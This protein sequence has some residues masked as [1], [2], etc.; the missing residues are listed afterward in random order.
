MVDP[1]ERREHLF[2]LVFRDAGAVVGNRYGDLPSFSIFGIGSQINPDIGAVTHGIV[3][4]VR[5]NPVQPN[6][7]P[8]V[9]YADTKA[10]NA[11]GIRGTPGFTVN[12]YFVSGAQPF[13]AFKKAIEKAK[14]DQKK[15]K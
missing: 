3:D 12:G 2:L 1:V 5:K 15:K 4:Q 9:T 14:A 8:L 11:A 6:G 10:A 13:P 7:S